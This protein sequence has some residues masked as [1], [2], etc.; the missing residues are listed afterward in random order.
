MRNKFKSFVE[1]HSKYLKYDQTTCSISC[2]STT[3]PVLNES[4]LDFFSEELEK[5]T[6]QHF[7]Q[8]IQEKSNGSIL[9]DDIDLYFCV[10]PDAKKYMEGYVCRF[11][12]NHSKYLAF[13][14]TDNSIHCKR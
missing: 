8:W 12:E 7:S 6:A 1:R 4:L 10:N 3:S 11:V 9:L 5:Y 13:D 14:W 2:I